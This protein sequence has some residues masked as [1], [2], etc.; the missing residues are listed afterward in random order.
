MKTLIYPLYNH[1][2]IC[3]SR[4][5]SFVPFIYP[6]TLKSTNHM[7]VLIVHP[8][9]FFPLS[10]IFSIISANPSICHCTPPL[11][12]PSTHPFHPAFPSPLS[13]HFTGSSVSHSLHPSPSS[14]H[15]SLL[16]I[17]HPAIICPVKLVLPTSPIHLPVCLSFPSLTVHPATHSAITSS[18]SSPKPAPDYA[19]GATQVNNFTR[20]GVSEMLLLPQ[21]PL[22][23][24]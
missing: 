7:D 10:C 23:S 3:P 19:T 22:G 20:K 9:N 13:L 15:L 17:V 4:I 12:L 24:F 8:I 2:S 18:H 6:I 5:P 21:A 11:T 14:I 1:L 16:I